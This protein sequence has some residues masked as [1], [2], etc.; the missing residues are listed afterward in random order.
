MSIS[1]EVQFLA[2]DV[3]YKR[4]VFYSLNYGV[5]LKEEELG[6]EGEKCLC[7]D[8]WKANAS[9]TSRVKREAPT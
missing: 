7:T 8:R 1:K 9:Q 4:A 6:R 3:T 2:L 5:N